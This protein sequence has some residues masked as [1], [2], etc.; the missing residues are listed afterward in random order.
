MSHDLGL[1][2]RIAKYLEKWYEL[3]CTAWISGAEIERLA[4][5][6]GKKASNASRRCRELVVD[7]IIERRENARGQVEYRYLP[8]NERE[9][10]KIIWQETEK[11]QS[12]TK[13]KT[14][15]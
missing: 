3:D 5:S 1:Y 11:M 15:L 10:V 13:Q 4:M 6:I 2:H 14:L 12:Q 7:Q 9:E 8:K